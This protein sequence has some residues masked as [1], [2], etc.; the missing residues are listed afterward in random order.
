MGLDRWPEIIRFV[1]AARQRRLLRP[2]S[3]LLSIFRQQQQF[4]RPLPLPTSA[5]SRVTC[6]SRK[7][8]SSFTVLSL[9]MSRRIRSH[10][11]QPLC[12]AEA[13]AIGPSALGEPTVRG[14]SRALPAA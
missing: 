7:V 2:H 6:H 11:L 13:P 8:S 3:L 14:H 4:S 1:P 9:H 12:G 5:I 10:L